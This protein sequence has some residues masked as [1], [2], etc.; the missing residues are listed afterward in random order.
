MQKVQSLYKGGHYF[1]IDKCTV[2]MNI[3]LQ[4]ERGKQAL[5]LLTLLLATTFYPFSLPQLHSHGAA[6]KLSR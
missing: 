3:D 2:M 6:E 4:N 5:L 1:Q